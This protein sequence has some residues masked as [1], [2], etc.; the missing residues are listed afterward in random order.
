MKSPLSKRPRKILVTLRS[1][2]AGVAKDART[3][4]QLMIGGNEIL[5]LDLV[6]HGERAAIGAEIEVLHFL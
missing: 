6:G 5:L 4:I 1:R 2:R 3:T